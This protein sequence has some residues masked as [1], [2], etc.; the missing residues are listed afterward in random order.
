M[1]GATAL[2]C[3]NTIRSPKRTKTITIGTSQYFFSC[4]KNCQSSKTTRRLLTMNSSEHP[5]VMLGIAVAF[6]VRRPPGPRVA[7]ARK[8]IPAGDP[9]NQAERHERD[10]EQNFQEHAT[11]HVREHAGKAPPPD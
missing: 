8:R 9:P 2:D 3:E 4:R 11:V 1:K 10:S 6:G 5:R 7:P